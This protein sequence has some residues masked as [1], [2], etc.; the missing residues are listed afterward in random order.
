MYVVDQEGFIEGVTEVVNTINPLAD[1]FDPRVVESYVPVSQDAVKAL[2]EQL[3]DK[4]TSVRAKAALALGILRASSA[5]PSIQEALTRESK[6]EVQ[7]EL[8]RTA[9]KIGDPS[10]GTYLI[11]LLDS[12]NKRVRDEAIFALGRLRVQ[13]AAQ[14]LMGFLDVRERRKVF[15][16]VPVSGKDDLQKR[17]L[18]ALAYI[19]D[20]STKG[21]FINSLADPRAEFRRYGAEGLGR[22]GESNV[23]NDIARAHLREESGEAKLAMS[24][25]LY[26]LGR[27]EHLIELVE[28]LKSRDQGYQYLLE[29]SPDE[30]PKLYPYLESERNTRVRRRL[31]DVIGL[32]GDRSAL[33]VIQQIAK[34]PSND[35]EIVGAANMA[36][37]RLQSR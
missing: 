12:S 35:S 26:R 5:L 24:F 11:P 1:D 21:L 9:Y 36:I 18:E 22:I 7:V 14:E 3:E 32:R 13:Q 30:V 37:R 29:M 28:S 34:N 25:A 33:E 19:G 10:V 31:I 16:V 2:Q 4:D 23:L 6:Q 8:V 15:G 20:P 27:E 17:A